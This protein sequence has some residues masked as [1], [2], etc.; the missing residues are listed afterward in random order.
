MAGR[1]K[2]TSEDLARAATELNNAVKRQVGF[3]TSMLALASIPFRDPGDVPYFIR[4]NDQFSLTVQPGIVRSNGVPQSVGYPFGTIPR[5][6]LTWMCTEA[7]STGTPD[8]QLG[9]NLSDFM[10]KIGLLKEGSRASGGAKGSITRLQSQME[11]LFRA[12][13]S[14]E[15]EGETHRQMGAG[16]DIAAGFELF[17]ARGAQAAEGQR[18]LLPARVI[19]SP[20][21]FNEV[22]RNPV[23]VDIAA[24]RALSGSALRLDLYVALTYYMSVIREEFLLSWPDLWLQLGSTASD[25]SARRAQLKTDVK[26]QLPAVLEVYPQAKVEVCKDGLRLFPSPPHVPLEPRLRELAAGPIHLPAM[27]DL[28]SR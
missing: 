15:V 10:R 20:S 1:P 7:V 23:P 3:S 27:P 21:F 28:L 5:L 11:R 16:I 6:L 19:L 9:D 22:T 25:N 4:S 14:I 13:F 2:R 17:W 18:S 24:L 26:R 12:R 8:L